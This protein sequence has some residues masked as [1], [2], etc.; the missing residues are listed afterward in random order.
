[1]MEATA[2]LNA[3]DDRSFRLV[4]REPFGQVIE[5]LATL[6][7]YVPFMMPERLAATDP[8]TA[9]KE[10]VGSGPFRFL[11]EQWDV[12]SRL[13]RDACRRRHAS[14]APTVRH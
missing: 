4:L 9:V 7:G 14:V 1:M 2:S 3:I 8:N 12:T 13:S 10:I 11:P 5:S 6:S